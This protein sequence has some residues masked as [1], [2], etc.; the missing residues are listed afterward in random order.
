MFIA[1]L[2]QARAAPGLRGHSRSIPNH[3]GPI[4]ETLLIYVMSSRA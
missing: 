3:P 4:K 1:S 2:E